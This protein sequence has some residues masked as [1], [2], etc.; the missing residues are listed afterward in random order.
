MACKKQIKEDINEPQEDE[1]LTEQSEMDFKMNSTSKNGLSNNS[2][3][4]STNFSLRNRFKN[5]K[6]SLMNDQHYQ[7]NAIF[8]L[9]ILF[10]GIM[11][12][13]ISAKLLVVTFT[14]KASVC[15]TSSCLQASARLLSRMNISFDVCDNFF[16]FACDSWRNSNQLTDNQGYYSITQQV[17]DQIFDDLRRF[18]YQILPTSSSNDPHYKV[19]RFY[20]S[21]MA[22]N[23]I[24][25]FSFNY[26]KHE[27]QKVGGWNLMDNWN[28]LDWNQAIA[29]E[30]LQV[31]Y[32][33]EAFFRIEIGTDDLD[34]Q[35]PYI[36]KVID[37]KF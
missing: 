3:P 17:N 8:V 26:F 36:I 37:L 13:C 14:P 15:H 31:L 35:L 9:I 24:D 2:R 34:P 1:E 22:L 4:I 19:K 32:G 18:F 27:I 33:V 6:S 30:R 5:A 23:E 25:I 28:A 7:I 10:L 12:I 16:N 11:L 29:V 20:E 21:C